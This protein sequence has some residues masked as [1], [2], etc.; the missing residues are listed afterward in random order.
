MGHVWR[1]DGRDS[2]GWLHVNPQLETRGL[3]MLYNPLAQE[4]VRPLRLPLYYTGLHTRA[5]IREREGEKRLYE[6]DRH[7]YVEL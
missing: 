1:P 6:L 3:A 2:D 7:Y 4:A 5:L